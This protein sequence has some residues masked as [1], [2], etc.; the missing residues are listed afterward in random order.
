MPDPVLNSTER[1][2]PVTAGVPLKV[3]LFQPWK[4]RPPASAWPRT[5]SAPSMSTNRGSAL[6]ELASRP[7]SR[8][9]SV[10]VAKGSCQ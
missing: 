6:M 7:S 9:Q 10:R 4:V 2:T 3:V 1:S 8:D 5:S